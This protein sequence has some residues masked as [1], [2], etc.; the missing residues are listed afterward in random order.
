[1]FGKQS[2]THDQNHASIG[3]TNQ[4]QASTLTT[5][6]TLRVAS[7]YKGVLAASPDGIGIDANLIATSSA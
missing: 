4:D 6:C 5:K 1:M 3:P 2:K 7:R